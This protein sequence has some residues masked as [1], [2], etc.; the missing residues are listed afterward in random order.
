MDDDQYPK[1][2]ALVVRLLRLPAIVYLCLNG[3]RY[4]PDDG[5]GDYY[6]NDDDSDAGSERRSM[7]G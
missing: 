6:K 4:E 2:A 1:S 3:L 5:S 7:N